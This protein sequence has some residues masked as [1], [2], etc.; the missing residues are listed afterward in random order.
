MDDAHRIIHWADGGPTDLRNLVLLCL[1]CHT[2]VHHRRLRIVRDSA[3]RFRVRRP[4]PGDR[5]GASERGGG[6]TSDRRSGDEDGAAPHAPL[7]DRGTDVRQ[8]VLS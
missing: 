3:G 8:P 5:R 4:P 6:R 1:S 7:H 2:G